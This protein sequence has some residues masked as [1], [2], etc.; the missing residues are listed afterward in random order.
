[1]IRTLLLLLTLLPVAASAQSRP[2]VV[3]FKSADLAAYAALVA[4]F[5]SEVRGEV[6]QHLL[7]RNPEDAAKLVARVKETAPT[8]VLAVGP[9]A[10]NASAKGMGKIPVLFAMVPYYERYGLEG[11]NVVGIALTNDFTPELAALVAAFPNA[12]RIG[13]LHDPRYSGPQLEVLGAAAKDRGLRV[14]PLPVDSGDAVDKAL[15]GLTSRV[16]ALIM[17][18]DKTVGAAEVVRKL[19]QVSDESALPLVALSSTQV[20]EGALLSLSP[21][22]LGLGQQAGRLANRIIHEKVDPS[23]LAVARP[24][25][26]DLSLNLTRARKLTTKEHPVTEGLLTHAA[27]KGL[28]LRVF[29]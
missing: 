3:V 11:Q 6:E 22:Y 29:E 9:A 26:L 10:A 25:A 18:S 24:E 15:V 7:P 13:V 27:I 4:G 21:S 23:A 20:Q 8:M 28:T 14:I 19:I 1:M 17:V 16:D 5:S 12:R 2:R